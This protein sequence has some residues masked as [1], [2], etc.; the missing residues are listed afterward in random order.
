MAGE[1]RKRGSPTAH[2]ASDK[3]REVHTAYP[4][5]GER[6]VKE[7]EITINMSLDDSH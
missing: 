4:G 3:R 7:T 6:K 1:G 5:G 2:M